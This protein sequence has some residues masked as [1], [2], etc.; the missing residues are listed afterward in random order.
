[1]IALLC[2]YLLFVGAAVFV[3]AMWFADG[4]A[5]VGRILK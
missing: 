3:L 2:L 4:M 1:M 5:G